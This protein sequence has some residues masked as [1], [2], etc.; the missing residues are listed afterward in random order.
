MNIISL[1]AIDLIIESKGLDDIEKVQN[2]TEFVES[3]T[4]RSKQIS[5]LFYWLILSI[6]IVTGILLGK[7]YLSLDVNKIQNINNIISIFSF[8]F[9]SGFIILYISKK[10]NII[11][12][13]RKTIN[14]FW[15]YKS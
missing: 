10:E 11:E 4:S 13:I 1:R 12:I 7:Y 14:K 2:L 9:G 3:F 8:L 5:N 6:I 15:G